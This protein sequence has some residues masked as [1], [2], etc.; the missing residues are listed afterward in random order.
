MCGEGVTR[1]AEGVAPQ[2]GEKGAARG[3]GV[4]VRG[5]ADLA[6]ALQKSLA[7]RRR[8]FFTLPPQIW[9][10]QALFGAPAAASIDP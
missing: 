1:N 2:C 6:P 10:S 5:V 8:C 3:A 7:R 4:G 9:L